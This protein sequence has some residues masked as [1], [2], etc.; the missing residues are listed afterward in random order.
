MTTLIVDDEM[1][2]RDRLRR[3]LKAY[4]DIEVVG[5]AGDGVSALA[6]VDRLQPD[7]VFLDI[8]MP[9]LDGLSVAGALK[10]DGPAIIF[11]TAF[12]EH[13]LKAFEV[14]AIDYLV[15]PI[16]ENRLDEA[17]ER[18]RGRLRTE[19]H[20]PDYVELIQSVL[21]EKTARRLAVRCGTKFIVLDP[22]KISAIIARNHYA[23]IIVD[24]KEFLADDPLD[25]L[26]RRL[27]S[28]SFLRV[29]R[30]AVINMDYLQELEREGDRKYVA[31]LSDT[32]KTRIPVSR[33]K[34][35]S[36]KTRLGL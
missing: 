12:S 22:K 11:V 36:L 34:L 7:L 9:E 16:A 18:V 31:I 19:P 23:A 17:I 33:E 14:S 10:Q 35:E 8:E 32:A 5:E 25:V 27:N 4:P 1:P 15:K 13:A 2:A 20:R 26:T 24:G 30:S 3:L 6:E 21:G 28:Q 29:H